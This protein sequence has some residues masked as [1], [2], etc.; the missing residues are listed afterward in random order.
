MAGDKVT[1]KC[2]CCSSFSEWCRCVDGV[3]PSLHSIKR[4]FTLLVQ[5][6][7]SDK[8]RLSGL[9]EALACRTYSSDKSE[10]GLNIAPA[11]VID[12]GG[13]EVVPA[14]LIQA[15]NDGVKFE[16][17]AMDPSVHESPDYAS[18]TEVWKCDVV[19]Q[20]RCLDRNGDVSG[21]MA[22]ALMLFLTSLRRGLLGRVPWLKEYVP[23]EITEPKLIKSEIDDTSSDKW[24]E[25]IVAVQ[26][27]YIYSVFVATESKRLKDFSLYP[28]GEPG[29][30]RS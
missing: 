26:I 24:Y 20:F 29:N 13:T 5:Y 10:T 27:T 1:D 6:L 25:S 8:D 2:T 22:D 28:E 23:V 12:P 15:S 19:L 18:N 7:F 9:S 14:I 4:I 17:I 21:M 16:K 30:N 11:T 3:E